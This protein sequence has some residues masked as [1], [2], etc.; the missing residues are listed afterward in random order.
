[1]L[2]RQSSSQTSN[3]CSQRYSVRFVSMVSVVNSPL[4]APMP[5]TS[6]TGPAVAAA[7]AQQLELDVV[8]GLDR[9]HLRHAAAQRALHPRRRIG[10]E[11]G[12]VAED[13]AVVAPQVAGEHRAEPGQEP[14]PLRLRLRVL[15]RHRAQ[16]AREVADR[17]PQ[18]AAVRRPGP[19]SSVPSWMST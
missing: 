7:V 9:V 4:H 5:W 15:H 14:E 18:H 16:L 6:T 11:R 17:D 19:S 3:P 8:V 10:V 12:D 1:M 13:P 2:P